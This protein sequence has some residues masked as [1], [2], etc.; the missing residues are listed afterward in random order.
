MAPPAPKVEETPPKQVPPPEKGV[1]EVVIKAEKPKKTSK[2][3]P[4]KAPQVIQDDPN[5]FTI[6]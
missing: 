1:E 4:P 2:A 5:H 6:K 3:K